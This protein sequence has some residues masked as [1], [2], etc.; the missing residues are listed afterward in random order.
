MWFPYIAPFILLAAILALAVGFGLLKGDS[1]DRPMF[2]YER[3]KLVDEAVVLIAQANEA[4]P[5]K[6]GDFLEAALE[7][8]ERAQSAFLVATIKVSLADMRRLQ[9]RT[10]EAIALYEQA[11]STSPSWQGENPDL[12][13]RIER[14]LLGLRDELKKLEKK[15]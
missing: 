4:A 9:K 8:A 5:G 1:K 3:R 6:A 12:V 15:S 10:K 14:E 2:T 13:V 7:R 11:L